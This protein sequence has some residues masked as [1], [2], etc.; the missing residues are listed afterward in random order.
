MIQICEGTGLSIQWR[1]RNRHG[2]FLPAATSAHDIQLV[3]SGA[4]LEAHGLFF[5]L[6]RSLELGMSI[7]G[8]LTVESCGS[9]ERRDEETK[10]ASPLYIRMM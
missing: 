3:A 4:Q 10:G 6:P 8:R 9:G 5:A 2:G 7:L 1:V